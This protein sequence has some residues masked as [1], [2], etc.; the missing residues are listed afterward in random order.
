MK[1]FDA[2]KRAALNDREPQV[3]R[4]SL[5]LAAGHR[6]MVAG[7][8]QEATVRFVKTTYSSYAVTAR[9]CPVLVS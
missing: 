4:R 7:Q 9:T 3:F 1:V 6:N 8:H 2:H 5:L